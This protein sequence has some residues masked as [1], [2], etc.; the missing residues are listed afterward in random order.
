MRILVAHNHYKYAGGEDSAMRAEVAMLRDA[1][2]EVELFEVDNQIIQGTAAKIFASGSLF[3]SY[4]SSR[5][6]SELMHAFRPDIVHI[7]NWFPLLS[8][9]VIAVAAEAGIPVV[10]TLHNFRMLC[11]NAIL[12]RDGK[13]CRDCLG[14]TIPLTPAMHGCYSASRAGSAVVAAAFAYHRFA[15]TWQGIATFIALSE[16]QRDLLVEGGMDSTQIVVKPNFV[17][18]AG[19]PGDGTGGYALFVGRLTP[20]KGI[21]TV[22]RA[23]AKNNPPIPLKIMGAGPLVDE[24]IEVSASVRGVEYL[25]QRSASE[26]YAA[27]ATAKFLIFPSE[28]Y[29]PFALTIVEAFSHGTPVL[30]ADLESIS[31]LVKDGQTGVRFIPGDADDLAAK[32]R[33]MLADDGNYRSMR[34]RC[35]QIYEERYTD[36]I[37]YNLLTDIYRR[38]I[39]ANRMSVAA[40]L[41]E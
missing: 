5:K 14:K 9:S 13:V 15:G 24:V 40:S 27:M 25:G 7:H 36:K 2:H 26:V 23:W 17:K 12:Y 28:W 33:Q 41:H 30:A 19:A 1:G 4:S 34:R 16:F 37:N 11:A 18:D 3:Y 29:E 8:P 21:R 22:L 35:R 20:E 39:V 10:Q 32:V 31:E 6:M 38:A